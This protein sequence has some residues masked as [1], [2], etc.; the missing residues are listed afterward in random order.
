MVPINGIRD[1][2]RV[3]AKKMITLAIQINGCR[4]NSP[5]PSVIQSKPR[6]M[7]TVLMC[8]AISSLMDFVGCNNK[9]L[10][11]SGFGD[12]QASHFVVSFQ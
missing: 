9:I 6:L 7:G 1:R 8:M 2:S 3:M 4:R 11:H 5:K 10:T 12:C